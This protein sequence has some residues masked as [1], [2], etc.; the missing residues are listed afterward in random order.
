MRLLSKHRA[1]MRMGAGPELSALLREVL[2]SRRI[3]HVVETGTYLGLGSTTLVAESFPSD[4]IPDVF[5][6]IEVNW[7]SWRRA[8]RNLR[9]FRFLNPVWG[10]TVSA[11]AALQFVET[12][13]T[14]RNHNRHADV[15]IDDTTNPVRF[16]TSEIMGRLGGAPR[17]PLDAGRWLVDKVFSYAGDDLLEKYLHS[18]R[19]THPLVV[20]DS[21]GGIGYLEFSILTRVMQGLGYLVLL[22]DIGHIKHFR[23]YAHIRADPHFD[24]L[25]MDTDQGWLLAEHKS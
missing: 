16:Y 19:A 8:K 23:S 24:I 10:R 13:D 11:E 22:D 20:L 4:F 12:D 1:D 9:R 17:H 14:L 21:A 2:Q 5:V 7:K 18:F 3:S 25:G 6:T 15:F